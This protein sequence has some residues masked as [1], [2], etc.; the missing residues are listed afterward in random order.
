MQL[1]HRDAGVGM[2]ME[3]IDCGVEYEVTLC[4]GELC[5]AARRRWSLGLLA[6]L[7]GSLL[8]AVTALLAS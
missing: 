7:L 5:N 8:V 3:T 2:G 4:R 6:P 1:C